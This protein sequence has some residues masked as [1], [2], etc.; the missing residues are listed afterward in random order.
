MNTSQTGGY[1]RPIPTP[2]GPL[3]LVQF[4]QTVF[5]GLSGLD[6]TMVRPKWQ[7]APPKQPELNVNWMA[8]GIPIK[9]PD[10]NAYVGVNSNDQ[11]IFQRQEGLEI[12]CSFY[13]PNA[14]T[15]AE[16]VRDGFQIQQNL[17][18]LRLANMG[19]AAVGPAQHIPDL[20]NERF[21]DRWEMSVFLRRQVQHSYSISTFLSM[22]GTI[23]TVLGSEEYLLNVQTPED[24]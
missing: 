13:G 12:G 5:V 22:T 19:F 9:T 14:D 17:D 6:G 8:Y 4:I 21:I 15:F 2:P 3:T 24:N 1:L 11:T 7:V 18:A 10:A 16:L 23:H 20:L